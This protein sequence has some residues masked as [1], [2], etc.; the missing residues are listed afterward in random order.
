[1]ASPQLRDTISGASR[2]DFVAQPT[3]RRPDF[4]VGRI[5]LFCLAAVV[6]LVFVLTHFW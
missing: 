5:V 4:S 1:M 6:L 3:N 2:E